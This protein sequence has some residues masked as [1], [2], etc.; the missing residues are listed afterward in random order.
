MLTKR[1]SALALPLWTGFSKISAYMPPVMAIGLEALAP[2]MK[3]KNRKVDQLGATA[4]AQVKI[5]NNRNGARMTMRL[6]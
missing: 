1:Y 4:Q 5:E 2:Q 6:P 3:R